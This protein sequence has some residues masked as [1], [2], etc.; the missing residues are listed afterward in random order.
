[1][2]REIPKW[3]DE[4]NARGV[5]LFGPELDLSN[6]AAT[7]RVR[8]G[9]TLVTE[10][11]FAETKEFMAGFDLLERPASTRRSKWW[12]RAPSHGS[13]IEVR[14]FMDGLGVG[15]EVLASGAATTATPSHTC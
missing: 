3:V 8:N 9:E 2:Q 13:H 5:R 7:V 6:T 1:M 15:E 11:P 12:P 14:P 10:C 4:M